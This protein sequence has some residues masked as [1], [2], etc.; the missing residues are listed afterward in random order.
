MLT[1]SRLAEYTGTTVRA[2]RHYHSIGLLPEPDRTASGY[3]SYGAQAVV[4]LIRI[5]TLAD[6]GVPLRRI[7][8]LVHAR[9]EELREAVAEI[10]RGIR[11]RIRELQTTRQ[12]LA[13]LIEHDEPFVPAEIHQLQ[14]E[15]RALGVSERTLAMERESWILAAALFPHLMDQWY[16]SQKSMMADPD[17]RDLYLLTDQAFGWDPSDPRIDDVVSR[18]VAFIRSHT[19]PDPEDEAWEA[20]QIAYR[21]VTTYR[22]EE[23]PAWAVIM[24]RLREEL[25]ED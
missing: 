15:M 3:R 23:S 22:T 12:A 5:R 14:K 10:D 11:D 9:P 18:T 2:I 20:D 24:R 1:I 17:Y 6:A 13:R 8:E 21:L 19:T 7:A 4:D 16:G 25:R